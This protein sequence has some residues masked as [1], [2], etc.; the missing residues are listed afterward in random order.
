MGYTSAAPAATD[1]TPPASVFAPLGPGTTPDS[2]SFQ[3]GSLHLD[4]T[5]PFNATSRK[6]Y[7][8]S[9]G[10][11]GVSRGAGAVLATDG[12]SQHPGGEAIDRSGA[13]RPRLSLLHVEPSVSSPA[14]AQAHTR[15]PLG[16]RQLV[17]SGRDCATGGPGFGE[18]C[19]GQLVGNEGVGVDVGDSTGAVPQENQHRGE[20]MVSEDDAVGG[21]V[22]RASLPVGQDQFREERV[23]GRFTRV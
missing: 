17:F 10:G 21:A 5:P 23:S 7:G 2:D 22:G 20:W 19:E 1:S 4:I 13:Q 15:G 18:D 12:V 3:P 14:L 8:S 6:Q 9:C 11:T 16:R